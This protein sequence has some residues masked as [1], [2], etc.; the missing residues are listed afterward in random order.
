MPQTETHDGVLPAGCPR[1][2]RPLQQLNS[3]V[4]SLKELGKNQ[5]DD[6]CD[7]ALVTLTKSYHMLLGNKKWGQRREKEMQ[8][9]STQGWPRFELSCAIFFLEIKNT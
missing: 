4:T 5:C 1:W 6:F 9:D 8:A 7:I 2:K 3:T